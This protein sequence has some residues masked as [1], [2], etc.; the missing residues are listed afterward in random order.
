MY[1]ECLEQLSKMLLVLACALSAPAASSDCFGYGCAELGL[2]V[3]KV[4]GNSWHDG[5]E[6][7]VVP[8]ASAE[9][10]EPPVVSKRLPSEPFDATNILGQGQD[11][12]MQA[13][14]GKNATY[15]REDC[16][17]GCA[18]TPLILVRSTA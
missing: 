10:F 8:Y 7:L 5:E 18:H 4:K 3:G 12:C 17:V 9:R 11:A 13:G 15:G 16:L 1:L 6:Y 14:Y 2:S